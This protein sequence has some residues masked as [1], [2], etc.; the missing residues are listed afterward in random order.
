MSKYKDLLIEISKICRDSV[1][2]P[3]NFEKHYNDLDNAMSTVDIDLSPLIRLA[4]GN[5]IC[6]SHIEYMHDEIIRKTNK[7]VYFL[8]DVE[9]N[10]V[11]IGS[12]FKPKDRIKH[13]HKI[14]GRKLV[15]KLVID[16]SSKKES[17]LHKKYKKYNHH[18]EWFNVD[19]ELKEFLFLNS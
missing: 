10:L 2:D 13:I 9:N 17:E 6:Q 1:D 12:S 14:A 11:K 4:V 8:L 3:S 15:L 7:S 5:L 16:G 19:G 18:G